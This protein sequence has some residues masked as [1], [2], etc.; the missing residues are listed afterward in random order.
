MTE[1][2]FEK[3]LALWR[4]FYRIP[5]AHAGLAAPEIRTGLKIIA[6]RKA[7]H[8]EHVGKIESLFAQWTQKP[9][10]G[11]SCGEAA[12]YAT[13]MSLT[14]KGE[15]ILPSYSCGNIYFSVKRSGH[16]PVFADIDASYNLTPESISEKLAEKTVA[17][18]V[19]SL[20]GF[21]ASLERIEKIV[22]PGVLLLD[23][24]AQCMGAKRKGRLVGT[25]G[26]AGVFSFGA[27]TITATAGGL[28][29]SSKKELLEEAERLPSEKASEVAFR[30]AGMLARYQ[31]R[32]K[33]LPFLT[34]KHQ[35]RNKG[36]FVERNYARLSNLDAYLAGSQ[37]P[38]IEAINRN[39][40]R[41]ARILTDSL[42]N[43]VTAPVM[44]A[45]HVF[46]KYVIRLPKVK[47]TASNDPT[48]R[49]V[50]MTRFVRAMAKEG[51]ECEWCYVPLHYRFKD[52]VSLPR[53][54][55]LWA[56][57]IAIPNHAGLSESEVVAVADA[58]K[59]T[60]KNI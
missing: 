24:A 34:L 51:I 35:L 27:K 37:F 10:I 41:N 31:Y 4:K 6:Q 60:V 43:M 54:E 48:Q 18:I 55:S 8:G 29:V 52:P 21:P 38:R 47:K 19:P 15:V 58:A 17:V 46:S 5:I 49:P 9:C 7:V 28:L 44:E 23:D 50:E 1:S 14:S 40:V 42:D 26:D 33:C 12:L 59:R 2:P 57:S 3:M 53:T 30:F 16:V 32:K 22:P 25:F 11:T 45:S 39:R 13:L 56:Q 20:Y 36:K